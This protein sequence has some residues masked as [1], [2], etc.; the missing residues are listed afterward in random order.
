[1]KKFI[2]LSFIILNTVTGLSQKQNITFNHL[3]T[4]DGLSQFS[5]NSLYVDELGVLWIGTREGLNRY[6]GNDIKTF[7]LQ[8]NNPN[9]LFCNTVLRITGDQ[10]GKV[11]LLCTEGVAEFD[12]T[13]QKFTTLL[14]GNVT[15]IYFN[16]RLFIGKRDE[17]YAYNKETRNFDLF[18]HLAGKDISIS[19]LHLDNQGNLW[20]GTD[21]SGF[22]KLD[23]E[24][25]LTHPVEKGNITSIY[26]DSSGELWIGSWEYGLYHVDQNGTI[27]NMRHD[28]QNPN[29]VASDFVRDCCEDNN[30]NIWIGTFKGLNRYQKSNGR[31][32]NYVADNGTE[33]LTH[34]S[35]WCIVKDAQGTLWLGTYFGGVN[36]FNPEYE[37]Y[38][39]YKAADTERDGLSSPII[40]R[41][42][43]DKDGNLWIGTE[44]GGVNVYHRKTGSFQWFRHEENRNS[45][46]HNNVK[47]I[48]YD[49]KAER[50]WIG[51]HLGGLNK[52]DLR[53]N[54]FTQYRMK[55]DDPNSLPSDIIRDII[56][57]RDQLIVGTQNG[58]C[59][60][61]P[62]TGICQQMFKDTKEGRTIKMVAD[63]LIDKDSTLWIAVTGEGVYAYRFD[64]R[65]FTNYR[66]EPRIPNSLSNNN[67]NSIMQDSQGNL[68]FS[69]SGSGLD[70]YRKET[71][72]FENFD[73]Q[74]SGL[75]SDC[76][77]EVCESSFE[78][79]CL[80]LITN[81]G[82]S[83]FDIPNKTFH[84][85][86]TENG[87]PLTA[88][89][90]NALYITH[91]GEVFLG[92]VQG[93]ISFHE[94]NLRFTP[95]SYNILLS[96][97]IINGKEVLPDDE[98]GILQHSLPYTPEITLKANQNMFSIEYTTS[99]YIPANRDKILY[100]LEGFSN[101]WNS[102]QRRQNIITYTNL[103]PGTYTLVV[104]T[105]REEI[106]ESKL[107]IHILPPWYKTWWAYL[108]YTILIGSLLIYLIQAYNSKI[109]LRESLK[110]EKKHIEDLEALNQSKLRFFT[111]I[112][113][114][115]RTP[116]TL[117]VGQIEILLQLQTFTP[118]VYNKIL[119]IYKSSL[120]LR[121]LISEL[122]DFR[123]QEQG[124]MKIKVSKHN[125]VTFLYENYLLFLE[126]A[127][128]KKINFN[129]KK[130]EEEIEVWYDQ[131]QLQKV[132]NN[133]LSNALKHT[134]EEDTIS[135][136]VK[137]Q[138]N[139]AII[140]I[141]DTGTGIDAKEIDKIFDRF[142]Q[143]ERLDTLATGAGTGI[144]LALTKGIIE[145]H[146]GTIA[147]ESEVGKGSSFII[148]LKLG[149]G[150]FDPE[151]ISLHEEIV[152]QPEQI[153]TGMAALMAETALDNDKAPSHPSDAKMLIVEDDPA[154]REMLIDV[155]KTFYQVIAA[156]DGE[157]AMK[158]VQQEMPSIVL[159]DVVMPHMS[160]TE[161][162]K[163][164]KGDFNTCHIPVV[165]LTARTAV[166]HTIEGLRIGADDYITKPFNINI[167]ISRCNNLVN[168]RIQLQEKF[169]KQ[170]QAFAQ[171]LATNPMD[172]EM[173]DRAMEIIERHLDNT[174]FN[175]NDF[176]REMGMARTNLFTK[177]KAVTG[178]TP[179][180][181]I[182]TIRLKKGA[183]LLRNHPELN[184]TEISDKVGF[185]S[186]RY[187]SK[188]FKD[189]YH[190]SPMSYRKG[191]EEEEI[192]EQ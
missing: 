113:H 180:D 31:F 150:H 122:L 72:D 7:K 12:L 100:R 154:I 152:Q 108:I 185:S 161:L 119:K 102:V 99:N 23:K 28:P 16:K 22:Y 137:R 71:N 77:Y 183:I 131:K 144:G 165:L 25:T 11:Y 50:M 56:P 177:L 104:K 106:K 20:M 96:R 166:E 118:N 42:V 151:Q 146:H 81:Q 114:E 90:E 76:I 34:S 35:I 61:D 141:R 143:T 37:I 39:R 9:S 117:I 14:Q 51:T 65:Q 70:L 67:V 26:Q 62:A 126:Y 148:T 190:V 167:L 43:E 74:K 57:Y 135:I 29:S 2:L 116:L 176:A 48:Y 5:V 186:S 182:L 94:T 19:C 181:F 142:Y 46:S 30:G 170:P 66:H 157:E 8:K 41:M 36:Y 192:S 82:F 128:S 173:I 4:D 121:E 78:K 88:V 178:Q 84:N 187:F 49:E 162:C 101:E 149:N 59:L 133:L 1:M 179:N 123:K 93:M 91:D 44:G 54:H 184:I 164:I 111:N 80:L 175:V 6:N 129:F 134:K 97:L 130:E 191:E 139:N 109:R 120:Q 55:E 64:T 17:V 172:K 15:S 168:S 156:S 33:S 60:F 27:H 171:I 53:T 105:Q 58:V 132:I 83:Q 92:G 188:C 140:T 10:K 47:A 38:T 13:T 127:S 21:N 112:S 115:F 3:T 153:P 169:S 68:W 87:F 79:D 85:Y 110:Y 160:G 63:L 136:S 86:S 95:K 125:L 40:G 174:E 163:Q 52:L 124:H 73:M 138:Q 24:K 45:I 75:S 98:T 107:E 69:T 18:Y 158:L 189:V 159:S 103:N 155:F 89:N 32:D 145:L 147:V